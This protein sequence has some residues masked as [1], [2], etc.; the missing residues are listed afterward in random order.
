[1]EGYYCITNYEGLKSTAEKV[2]IS[3]RMMCPIPGYPGTWRV[4]SSTPR[5]E[6]PEEAKTV[7]HA[8]REMHL[9]EIPREKID[10]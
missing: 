1:M 6:L 7:V 8:Y 5:T 4:H 10:L 9:R 3:T 2:L